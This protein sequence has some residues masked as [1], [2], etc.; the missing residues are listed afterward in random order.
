MHI[1]W[2]T[3]EKFY[4]YVE[5]LEYIIYNFLAPKGYVLNGNVEWYGEDRAD[6]GTIVVKSNIVR[7]VTADDELEILRKENAEL[8]SI[9]TES[10]LLISRKED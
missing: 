6:V 1:E 3:G 4:D 5:W 10:N 9:I 2:D 7:R 8:K